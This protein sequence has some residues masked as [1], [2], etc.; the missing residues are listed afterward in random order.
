[1]ST[2]RTLLKAVVGLK[3]AHTLDGHPLP[4]IVEGCKPVAVAHD[5]RLSAG[6]FRVPGN[7]KRS[8]SRFKIVAWRTFQDS[9]GH[10]RATT[11]LYRDEIDPILRLLQQCGDRL[12]SDE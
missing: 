6:I 11:T 5:R 8:S 7:G 12:P 3:T 2:F 1:M 9:G 4:R 10:E